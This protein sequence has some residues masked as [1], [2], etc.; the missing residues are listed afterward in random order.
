MTIKT[1]NEI[2]MNFGKGGLQYPITIPAGTRVSD[3]GD[4]TGQFFVEDISF[5][6]RKHI[7]W[8]DANYYGIRLNA[9]QVEVV[10]S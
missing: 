5:I 2:T 10:E 4:G 3:C 6:D 1:K 8:H 9:D 7:V